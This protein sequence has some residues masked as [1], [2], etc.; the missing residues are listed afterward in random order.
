MKKGDRVQVN[1]W[2]RGVPEYCYYKGPGVFVRTIRANSPDN[3]WGEKMYA[4][5]IPNGGECFF[6]ADCVSELK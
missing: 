4:I 5:E 6:P 2:E 1:Y 3:E